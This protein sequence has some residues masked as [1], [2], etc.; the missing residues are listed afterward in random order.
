LKFKS[1]TEYKQA[2]SYILEH[3]RELS[4]M[5]AGEDSLLDEGYIDNT[6]F[7]KIGQSF[8]PSLR[9]LRNRSRSRN[10]SI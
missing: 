4:D 10:R 9:Y 1:I 3:Q 7:Y 2:D 6:H 5:I 8:N